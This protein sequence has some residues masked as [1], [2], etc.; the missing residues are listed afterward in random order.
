MTRKRWNGTKYKE[1]IGKDGY[2][3]RIQIKEKKTT[4]PK[5]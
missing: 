4:K 1:V 5:K 2:I 3:H